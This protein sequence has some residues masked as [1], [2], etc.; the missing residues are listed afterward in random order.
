MEPL[1]PPALDFWWRLP[2]FQSQGGPLACF[3]AWVILRFTS[4][5][6]PADCIGVSLA[7]EPFWSMYLQTWPQSMVEVWGLNPWLSVLH[8]AQRYKPLGHSGSALCGSLLFAPKTVFQSFVETSLVELYIYYRWLC[9][10]YLSECRDSCCS[11]KF[12]T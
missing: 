6:T 8:A 10:I 2:G 12:S 7:T 3:L 1:I 5:V 4:G 11:L 9:C